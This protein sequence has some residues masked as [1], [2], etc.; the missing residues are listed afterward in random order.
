[1]RIANM[2]SLL[3]LLA[4]LAADVTPHPK[5]I[6]PMPSVDGKIHEEEWADAKV[7]TDFFTVVPKSAEKFYDST[8]VYVKQSSDA[9]YFAFKFHP[10]AKVIRQSLIRDVSSDEENEFFILLDLE[11][12]NENGYIFIFNFINNQRD[13]AVY[14]QRSLVFEWDWVWQSRS[15]VYRDPTPEQPGYIETEVRIPVDKIQNK[16]PKQ[17]GIDLQMFAYKPD[18]SSYFYA[19]TPESEI[20]TVKSM[21]KLDIEP[22]E[23]SNAPVVSA[24]PFLRGQKISDAPTTGTAGGDLNLAYGLHKLKGT[25]QTDESTLEADPFQFS[26]YGQSIYLQEKRPFLSKDLDIYRTP[27][28]LFYTRAIQQINWGTNYTYRSN[29][30]KAGVVLVEDE[31]PGRTQEKRHHAVVRTNWQS[32]IAN[33][34]TTLMYGRNLTAHSTERVASFDALVNLPLGFRFFPQF[35]TNTHGNAYQL[36]LSMPRNWAGGVYGSALYRRFGERFDA[37][38]LFNDY[39]TEYDEA[40]IEIGYRSVSNRPLFPQ[41]EF[42]VSYYKAATLDRSLLYQEFVSAY[43]YNVVLEFLTLF[44]RVEYNRPEKFSATGVVQHRNVLIDN[45]AK[46]VIG[47]HALTFG[48]NFGPY[49]G[50]YLRNPYA[51]AKLIFW[52]RL[53]WDV[54]LN[55][56]SYAEVEQ[57]IVRVKLD[58]RVIDHLYLRSFIQKDNYRHQGLWNTL[59]QYEF[60]AGSNVYFVLNQEGQRF[61]NGGKFF[62]VGYEVNL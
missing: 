1:M 37:S 33:L 25:F 30:L 3:A 42:G 49:F 22:F 40:N 57:T 16:N 46:L 14:N 9:L 21:Y 15:T 38:T 59:L 2:L 45:N 6:R 32:G 36:S 10:R 50:A 4:M 13:I 56:R 23:E 26:L 62:K 34:G 61:E 58:V 11:N 12:R 44:H 24:I 41:M 19:L 17:I 31:T 29:E 48:Y 5:D 20:L 53:A 8:I 54:T 55:H 52:D 39:G 28:N 35:A 60:F 51:N 27:I 47:P 7:F 43:A 18:G